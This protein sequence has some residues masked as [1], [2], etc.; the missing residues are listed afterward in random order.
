MR[1]LSK[2]VPSK[3]LSSALIVLSLL[4]CLS[5]YAFSGCDKHGRAAW[6]TTPLIVVLA[7]VMVPVCSVVLVPL[8]FIT[9]RTERGRLGFYGYVALLVGAAPLVILGAWVLLFF[10]S[11]W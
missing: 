8:F 7:I 9:R 11:I 6:C 10:A 5:V 3:V 2:A 1:V 4:W